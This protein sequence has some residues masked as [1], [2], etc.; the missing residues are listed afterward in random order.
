[1][2]TYLL[3]FVSLFIS[4]TSIGQTWE[5]FDSIRNYYLEN[6]SYDT[7]LIYAKKAL[8]SAKEKFGNMDT[9]YANM[10]YN[11][12]EISYRLSDYQKA[13]EYGLLEKEISHL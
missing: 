2:K 11:M 9:I 13:I 3:F 6:S 5:N 10:L 7:A 1:M 4:L 12:A 8:Q